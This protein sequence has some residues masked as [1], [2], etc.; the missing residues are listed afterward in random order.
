M[1]LLEENSSPGETLFDQT[2]NE[3][4]LTVEPGWDEKISLWYRGVI[5]TARSIYDYERL[6][7]IPQDVIK[8]LSGS[9]K[10]IYEI[11]AG[12]AELSPQLAKLNLH[13]CVNIDPLPYRDVSELLHEASSKVQTVEGRVKITTLLDR[14]TIYSNPK[15]IQQIGLTLEELYSLEYERHCKMADIVIDVRA[16]TM[17]SPDLSMVSLLENDWLLNGSF[18]GVVWQAGAFS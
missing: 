18:A 14:A 13:R 8:V 9:I 1:R 17:Y 12:L 3:L 15:C 5:V 6:N 11:G 4:R 7:A 16:A 10:N 2:H